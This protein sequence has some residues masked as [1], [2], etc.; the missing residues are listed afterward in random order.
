MVALSPSTSIII[1]A[2][3]T[4]SIDD[5][6]KHASLSVS[7]LLLHQ[8][9][10]AP[11]YLLVV[12]GSSG[13]KEHVWS[14]GH[15]CSIPGSGRYP[16]EGHGNPLQYSCLE[17]LMDRGSWWAIVHGVANNWTQLSSYHFHLTLGPLSRLQFPQ[18]SNL[19]R[20]IDWLAS[21]VCFT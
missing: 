19:K 5:S 20:I 10:W 11:P 21:S 2:G 6:S 17:N 9:T 18:N 14:A 8:H 4:V 7:W 13:S 12:P 15:V 3:F 1:L 16:G